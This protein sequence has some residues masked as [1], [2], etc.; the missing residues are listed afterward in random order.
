MSRMRVP[1]V[2]GAAG[3]VGTTTLATALHAYDAG[4]S[5]G[6]HVDVL[7][8]RGT[9]ESLRRAE[10]LLRAL[11]GPRP[12]LAVT[13]DVP[14]VRRL[15]SRLRTVR[16]LAS[17]VV[18][19]PGVPRWRTLADPIA[20]AAT[21]LAQSPESLPRAL[22][23]YAEALRTVAATL[24]ASGRLTLADSAAGGTASRFAADCCSMRGEPS[25]RP[26]G[27][28]STQQAGRPQLGAHLVSARPAVHRDS[29]G[30]V[31]RPKPVRVVAP[32]R[33]VPVRVAP[34]LTPRPIRIS[35]TGTPREPASSL[36][37]RTTMS[38]TPTDR[39]RHMPES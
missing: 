6:P 10:H 36:L 5:V 15:P 21:L 27:A 37:R 14:G 31:E 16:R 33:L 8:C 32:P 30:V 24:T 25:Q 20:E 34:L 4:R 13:A 29:R 38:L 19:L 11:D 1:V 3:G 9:E 17:G 18:V 2:A 23:S 12:V 22:R 28:E 26:S 39:H 7:V 35:P